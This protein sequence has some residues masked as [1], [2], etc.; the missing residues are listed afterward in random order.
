MTSETNTLYKLMILYMLDNA[1]YPLTNADISDFIL[2][3]DYTNYFTIQQALSDLETSDLITAESESKNTTLYRITSNGR[4]TLSFFHDKISDAIKKDILQYFSN[5]NISLRKNTSVVADYYKNYANKY[6][7]RCQIMQKDMVAF[8][9]SFQ[10]EGKEQA[11]M[12]CENF[13]K[14]NEEIY[15]YLMDML[16]K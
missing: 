4:I 8:E 3:M 1:D 14:D 6:T 15:A 5:N 2:L 16:I 12:V 9:L 11:E 7:V 10:I 13:K